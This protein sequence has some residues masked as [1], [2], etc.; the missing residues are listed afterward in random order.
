MKPTRRQALGFVMLAGALGLALGVGATLGALGRYSARFPLNY[1]NR[2][3]DTVWSLY[4]EAK[5]GPPAAVPTGD[6]LKL[7][8]IFTPLR[9]RVFQIPTADRGGEGGAVT[10]LGSEL[11]L[12]T[13]DGRFF[14]GSADRGFR[15]IHKIV[16]PD[17]GYRQYFEATHRP[18][19]DPAVQNYAHYRYN[20]IAFFPTASGAG[21]L[22]SYTYYDDAKACHTTRL[23]RFDLSSAAISAEDLAIGAGDWRLLYETVPCLPLNPTGPAIRVK[24]AGGRMVVESATGTVYLA[25]GS[26]ETRNPNGTAAISQDP[27]NDYGKVLT[28][29][30]ATG[31]AR[32]LSSGH[33]NPQGIAKDQSGRIWIVEHGPRGGDEL[34]RIVD[35]RNYGWPLAVYGS[36]NFQRPYPGV[37]SPGRHDGFEQP[38]LAW[39]PSIGPG[40]IIAIRGFHPAWDGNL[41]VGALVGQKLIHIRLVGDRV[42]FAED[43]PVG[44]RVRHLHQHTD[45]SI[46]LWNGKHELIILTPGE[47][48]NAAQVAER[49]IDTLDAPAPVRAAA[50]A[51]LGGCMQCHS[52]DVGDNT[53]AP[54]LARVFG[55]D[56]ASTAYAHYSPAMARADGEWSR[57]R[58]AAFLRDPHSAIPGTAM[59][60]PEIADEKVRSAV[61]DLLA[62]LTRTYD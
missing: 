62:E 2:A 41:L 40:S 13:H 58:L 16:P 21:L 29:D 32:R 14:A 3:A 35:G 23:S 33:R 11:L 20:D 27:A 25:S 59:P 7:A 61:V 55:S 34:N 45:G 10:S 49:I 30:V 1:A 42:V 9:G 22:I 26:Y 18:P 54:S 50:R 15:Q 28:I 60:N 46:V 6:D 39:L 38:T 31:T 57:D 37:L 24:M 56:I 4:S 52:L 44:R 8:T 19:Y 48:S 51:E 53:K 43:I 36:D 47:Q 5:G 17:N 12:L